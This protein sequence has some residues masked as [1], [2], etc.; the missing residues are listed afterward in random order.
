MSLGAPKLIGT[1]WDAEAFL[2]AETRRAYH[3]PMASRWS[4]GDIVVR[5]EELGLQPAEVVERTG[6]TGVWLEMPVHI[7][8]D[9][10][11][12]LVSYAAPGA[13]FE[14]PDGPWPT[15]NGA[16]PWTGRDGW[17][18]R[19]CLMVQRPAEHVAVWHF[20][21]G[22]DRDFVCW[23]LNLQTAFVR[24]PTGYN[25]QDLELDIVVFPDGSHIVKDDEV[26]DDRVAEG[27]YSAEL[28]AWIR[29]Y[30]NAIIDRLEAEGPWWD[31]AWAQWTPPS[32]WG[33]PVITDR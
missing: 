22:P 20:W 26:L 4:A 24:T 8:D 1:G 11:E 2:A 23:Y 21:D 32:E 31:R 6:A 19:G 3:R 29:S 33:D 30:G 12:Q 18:G 25:T 15:P 16:H 10:P 13:R 17:S 7:V 28:V 14:F 27:R 9:T 5:R